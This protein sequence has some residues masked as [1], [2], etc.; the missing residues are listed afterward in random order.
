MADIRHL[1]VSDLVNIAYIAVNRFRDLTNI[2]SSKTAKHI[3]TRDFRDSLF[4]VVRRLA[5]GKSRTE[6]SEIS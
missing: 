6:T 2:C 1:I 3:R 4:G 5:G